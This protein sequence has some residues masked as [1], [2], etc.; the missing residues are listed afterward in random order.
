[1]TLTELYETLVRRGM[2]EHPR[3]K[4]AHGQWFI[5]VC[6]ADDP[7]ELVDDDDDARDLLTMHAIRWYVG[8][9]TDRHIDINQGGSYTYHAPSEWRALEAIV[10]ATR[11]LEPK[12]MAKRSAR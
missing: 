4:Y 5:L 9:G 11:H 6:K 7:W 3:L 8:L 10:A 1:M 2:P 12:R